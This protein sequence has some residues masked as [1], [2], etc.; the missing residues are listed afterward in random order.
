MSNEDRSTKHENRKGYDMLLTQ[1]EMSF[2]MSGAGHKNPLDG[3]CI[4]L[5]SCSTTCIFG[6]SGKHLLRNFRKMEK[7][8][9]IKC[10]G[11]IREA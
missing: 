11:G 2:H 1:M 7:G 6:R 5:D 10:N 3:D 8:V 9:K 4:L